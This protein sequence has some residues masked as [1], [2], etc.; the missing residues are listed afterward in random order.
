MPPHSSGYGIVIVSVTVVCGGEFTCN[1][2]AG[3]NAMPGS[4]I[5]YPLAEVFE[6]EDIRKFELL[7]A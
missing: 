5:V 6:A 2:A 4:P 3:G 7:L 1:A